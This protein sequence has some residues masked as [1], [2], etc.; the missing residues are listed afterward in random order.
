MTVDEANALCVGALPGTLGIRFVEIGPGRSVAE[1]E[2]TPALMAP[3]GF[4]HGGSVT[5]LADTACGFGTFATPDDGHN[6]PF[7]TLELACNFLGTAKEGVV[8]CTATIVHEGRTT[9][10]WDAEVTRA[11]GRRIAIFRATQLLLDDA[12]A[13]PAGGRT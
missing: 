7:A 11:D 10:V 9:Q 1:M 3:N 4:L 12:A 5:A 6:T 2:V 8:R 13:V